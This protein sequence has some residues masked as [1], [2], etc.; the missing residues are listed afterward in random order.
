MLALTLERLPSPIGVMLLLC[1]QMQQLRA[2]DWEDHEHRLRDLLRRQYGKDV[3]IAE[4]GKTSPAGLAMQAYFAGELQ[5]ID[6]IQVATGG[7]EFPTKVWRALRQVPAGTT[8]SYAGLAARIGHPAAIRATGAANGANPIS[9]V[10][11]CHRLVGGDGNLVK[12]GG[13]LHRKTWL[14]R[15]EGARLSP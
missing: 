3:Q 1:D 9:I 2:L 4:T 12:Y 8:L 14:L 13:G 7:T 6:A 5:A 11:P 15:H 10:V